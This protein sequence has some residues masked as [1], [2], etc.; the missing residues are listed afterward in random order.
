MGTKIPRGTAGLILGSSCPRTA[1]PDNRDTLMPVSSFPQS[2]LSIIHHQGGGGTA[3]KKV[4]LALKTACRDDFHAALVMVTCNSI[5]IN[6]QISRLPAWKPWFC[7]LLE[8][9]FHFPE[10]VEALYLPHPSPAVVVMRVKPD[11]L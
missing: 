9:I 8:N 5:R 7:C 6:T 4:L 2:H 1:V 10:I 11:D 3:K